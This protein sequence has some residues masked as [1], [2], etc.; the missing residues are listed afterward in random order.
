MEENEVIGEELETIDGVYI[1]EVIDSDEIPELEN[2]D[3][4]EYEEVD[5]SGEGL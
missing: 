1:D 3:D 5:E 4:R 2:P